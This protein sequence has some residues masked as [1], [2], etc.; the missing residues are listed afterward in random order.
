MTP[1]PIP[2]EARGLVRVFKL[3]LCLNNRRFDRHFESP[4]VARAAARYNH[5]G[6]MGRQRA[7]RVLTRTFGPVT[8][9]QGDRPS[10]AFL[11]ARDPVIQNPRDA[12]QTQPSVVVDYVVVDHEDYVQTGLWTME[13]PDH[14]L[15]RLAQR[16]RVVDLRDTILGA[17]RALLAADLHPLPDPSDDLFLPAGPGAFVGQ[18]TYGKDAS[19]RGEPILYFRARTWLHRDQLGDNQ[20]PLAPGQDITRWLG[21]GPLL[22]MPLRRLELH[23][24]ALHVIPRNPNQCRTNLIAP[25]SP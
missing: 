7:L 11:R 20:V 13:L 15:H 9:L 2:A 10:W 24:N 19:A 25:P 14:A 22:P 5:A 18:M 6:S 1:D 4:E 12:G 8:F 3:K 23:R 16:H 21:S 17:H